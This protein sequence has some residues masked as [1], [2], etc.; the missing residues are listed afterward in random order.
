MPEEFS[1]L[2]AQDMSKLGFMQDLIRGIKKILSPTTPSQNK[3][4]I[5]TPIQVS[6]NSSPVLKRAFMFLSDGAWDKAYEY[7]E[8][9]LDADPENSKAYVG[10]LLADLKIK[11]EDE[12][13]DSSKQFT[14]NDNFKKAV[15]FSDNEYRQLL[16]S[17]NNEN[18]YRRAVRAF[19]SSRTEDE[20]YAAR[21]IF[22]PIAEYKDTQDLIVSCT[23]KAESAR[24]EAIKVDKAAK[25][26][27]TIIVTSVITLAIALFT[28]WT[29][30]TSNSN[31]ILAAEIESNFVG[32]H[33]SYTEVHDSGYNIFSL[34]YKSTYDKKIEFKINSKCKI[35]YTSKTVWTE[36]SKKEYGHEDSYST[37]TYD[38]DYNV[39]ISLFGKITVKIGGSSYS[40]TVNENNVP[41]YITSENG[42]VYD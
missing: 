4:N 26:K 40:V 11:T 10:L 34:G 6:T 23:E 37:N 42:D 36:K 15:Q 9:V 28:L 25:K 8:K 21:K 27:R 12:L 39:Y 16:C 3:S 1:H 41:K 5:E 30:A 33:F 29:I 2:Q 38:Y 19:S 35:T 14:D 32:K 18:I 7:C 31:K 24:I 22:L 17:Y 13:V 20:Y